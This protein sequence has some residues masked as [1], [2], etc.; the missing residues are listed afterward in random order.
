MQVASYIWLTL[1][2]VAFLCCVGDRSARWWVG[3][4]LDGR[5]FNFRLIWQIFVVDIA[6]CAEVNV[7]LL[8]L[9]W[10]LF[11]LMFLACHQ[12]NRTVRLKLLVGNHCCWEE[13]NKSCKNAL[14]L[15]WQIKSFAMKHQNRIKAVTCPL[16]IKE[17]K[18]RSRQSQFVWLKQIVGDNSGRA[19]KSRTSY[20]TGGAETGVG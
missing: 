3:V 14:I 18:S 5:G 9:L 12:H 13:R 1:L 8:L 6:E 20:F 17:K 11:L 16:A 2:A 10:L 7:I 19:N 4:C 15:I